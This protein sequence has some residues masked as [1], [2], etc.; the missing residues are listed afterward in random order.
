M[1][2]A[3]NCRPTVV[4]VVVIVGLYSR[5]VSCIHTLPVAIMDSDLSDMM[6]YD[7]FLLLLF[8]FFFLISFFLLIY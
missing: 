3:C 2:R 5:R 4:V 8:F 1:L 7:S 6:I